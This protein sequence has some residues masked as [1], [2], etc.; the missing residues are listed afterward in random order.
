MAQPPVAVAR[1]AA[2]ALAAA[3]IALGLIFLWA[4]LDKLLGL[5]YTTPP[6][7]A[8]TDGGEPTRGYLGSSYGPLENVF[9]DMAGNGLVDFLFMMGLLAVGVTLTLGIAT[10]LGGWSGV[11]MVLLMYASHP[12][13]W[14]EPNGTH[15]FLDS[16]IVE[17]T[18]LAL[19]ALTTSGHTWGM[20]AWW[21]ARTAKMTWLR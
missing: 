10:R 9:Q 3:R 12:T 20:G 17:A 5:K 14:A 21:N 16:H 11:A 13:P 4:F 7:N 19:I 6:A 2:F 8:W 15:P 1:P 18:M